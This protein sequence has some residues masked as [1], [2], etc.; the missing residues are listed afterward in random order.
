MSKP[1]ADTHKDHA[2]PGDVPNEGA[3]EREFEHTDAE[4]LAEAKDLTDDEGD[5]IRQYSGEPVPTEHGNVIPQQ[6]AAGRDA[7]V[8][9][10]QWP[11]EPPRGVD[12]PEPEVPPPHRPAKPGEPPTRILPD[13]GEPSPIVPERLPPLPDPEPD[14]PPATEPDPTR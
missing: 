6:M 14:E 13:P 11:D 1:N 3:A 5:D 9:G 4:S 8:G 10:G 7:I 12:D 2:P